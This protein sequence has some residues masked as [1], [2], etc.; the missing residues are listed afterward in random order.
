MSK[1]NN[2]VDEATAS[3]TDV[4]LCQLRALD[5]KFLSRGNLV[6]VSKFGLP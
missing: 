6:H 4:W 3:S 1:L 2:N 5:A